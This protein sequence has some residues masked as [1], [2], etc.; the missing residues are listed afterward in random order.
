MSQLNECVWSENMWTFSENEK[1]N[2]SCNNIVIL[3]VGFE[4]LHQ[5][6]HR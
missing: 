1:G 3:N 5:C 4:T 2:F 6:C